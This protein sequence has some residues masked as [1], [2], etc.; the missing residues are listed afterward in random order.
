MSWRI[1]TLEFLSYRFQIEI[2]WFVAR[3]ETPIEGGSEPILPVHSIQRSML[4][5]MTQNLCILSNWLLLDMKKKRNGNDY[6]VLNK[7]SKL[8]P[9]NFIRRNE[10]HF[11]ANVHRFS[12]ADTKFIELNWIRIAF[13]YFT[14][15]DDS[16]AWHSIW[17][18]Q[19]WLSNRF[20]N[21]CSVELKR[22]IHWIKR[23]LKSNGAL[24]CARTF[25]INAPATKHISAIY[26]VT[27]HLKPLKLPR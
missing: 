8:I 3:H 14:I 15:P 11:V 16:V 23:T 22:G 13:T 20:I 4:A 12:G 24:R 17:L 10:F 19:H 25:V 26:H 2:N 21:Q 6:V 18:F 5:T 7:F 1:F 27:F 9:I